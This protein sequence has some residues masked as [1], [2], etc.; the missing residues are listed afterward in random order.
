LIA[1]ETAE[2]EGSRRM[3][4]GGGRVHC[5]ACFKSGLVS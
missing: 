3:R 5:L 4:F 2:A 1:Q